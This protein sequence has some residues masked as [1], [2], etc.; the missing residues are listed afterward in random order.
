MS[1]RM[2]ERK[3]TSDEIRQFSH[4]EIDGPEDQEGE[5]G[6]DAFSDGSADHEFRTYSSSYSNNAIAGASGKGNGNTVLNSVSPAGKLPYSADQQR[7]NHPYPGYSSSG[8]GGMQTHSNGQIQ[9][10]GAC[11]RLIPR[12][13][14][15]RD[16]DSVMQGAGVQPGYGAGPSSHKDP[17][18][19]G[20]G[21]PAPRIHSPPAPPP[22]AVQHQ[23]PG[24][25]PPVIEVDTKHRPQE[26]WNHG[27]GGPAGAS[28]PYAGHNMQHRHQQPVLPPSS[29]AGRPHRPG[30][31]D[32]PHAPPAP[33]SQQSSSTMS[34]GMQYPGMH[35]HAPP[36]PHGPPP[37]PHHRYM[38]RHAHPGYSQQ[39]V[40][41]PNHNMAMAMRQHHM[42]YPQRANMPMM[43]G[44]ERMMM[45]GPNA[46]PDPPYRKPQHIKKPLNAFMLFMKEQRPIVVAS[47][48]LKESAAINQILG[49]M[50]HN[51]SRTE[52]G[53]Y[54]ELAREERQQH[55]RMYPNYNPR[56]A[57]SSMGPRKG[58]RPRRGDHLQNDEVT[59][60]KKC[61]A[62]Y[63]LD[64]TEKW[65]KPC[66]RKKKCTKFTS[67]D[68]N[69][70]DEEESGEKRERESREPTGDKEVSDD[71]DD[72]SDEKSIASANSSHDEDDFDEEDMVPHYNDEEPTGV[73]TLISPAMQ[74]SGGIAVLANRNATFPMADYN[75]TG[76]SLFGDPSL[77]F[78]AAGMAGIA[79][80]TTSSA[81]SSVP[82]ALLLQSNGN[83]QKAT[84]GA[85]GAEMCPAAS[86]PAEGDRDTTGA[87]PLVAPSGT[88][89]ISQ[90]L[91]AGANTLKTPTANTTL[92]PMTTPE[93]VKPE[94][95]A[96]GL[97]KD[98]S[99]GAMSHTTASCSSMIDLPSKAG[100][101]TAVLSM[102][103][104]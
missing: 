43:M 10:I 22:P 4:E 61:R 53:K 20:H 35:P 8:G 51:L 59:Q 63:G 64:H 30:H 92:T 67:A 80:S 54:Y 75:S 13:D 84:M 9:D 101:P 11:P 37:P 52:Q 31:L 60:L 55:Q 18:T 88:N 45:H 99:Q 100:A 24:V 98:L 83:L 1:M 28:G 56:E 79:A 16:T 97:G 40:P 27:G 93:G 41:P 58:R 6:C 72:D 21:H 73:H 68:D 12:G 5:D 38:P 57:Y 96:E 91:L 89:G 65:C 86:T 44:G 49:K 70:S 69:G 66:R 48:S 74:T 26:D 14:R 104:N 32:L 78:P 102:P 19:S 42:M 29:G 94:E 36:H 76:G 95:S 82:P 46:M 50:W 87:A 25:P 77:K 3:P 62:R 15:G 17:I 81:L 85:A 7:G 39:M 2:M 34:R 71:D 103:G 47:C 33:P 23:H 90:H